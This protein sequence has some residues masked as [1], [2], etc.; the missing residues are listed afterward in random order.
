MTVVF[1]WTGLHTRALRLAMRMSVRGFAEYL[2]S[3]VRAVS[4]WEN[5]GL[6]RR[7][8]PDMQAALDTAL[9]RCD[10]QTRERFAHQIGAIASSGPVDPLHLQ[11]ESFTHDLEAWTDDLDRASAALNAQNFSFA[12]H[13]LDRWLS[14]F[15]PR[16]LDEQALHLYAR[17][18]ALRGDL[19]RDQ[20]A[21]A[22]PLS[23]AHAYGRAHSIFQQLKLQRRV[24]QLDLSLA[25]VDEMSGRLT[26]A[27]RRYQELA[28]DERLPGRDRA[29]ALLWVGTAVDKAGEHDHAARVMTTASRLFDDLTEPEDWSVAQQKLALAHRSAGRLGVAL[30]Y[31]GLA[32]SSAI[33]PSPLQHV[34]QDTAYGHILLSDSGTRREG[35]RIL[36]RCAALATTYGM[37]HQLRSIEGIRRHGGLAPQGDQG[38]RA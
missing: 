35:Q 19:L 5:L 9:Q 8:R 21:I 15:D 37:S 1:E 6:A 26:T 16:Q 10:A 24:A 36:E 20:G 38:E 3:S 13:L 31:I 18:T 11:P 14:R 25:V 23:A 2:G 12:G 22:G 32:R 29:R 4:K 34:R 33:T 27:A 28:D 7:P 30:H 17:G